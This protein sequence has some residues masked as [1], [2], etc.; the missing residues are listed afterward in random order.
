MPLFVIY[1]FCFANV[2]L[3][4]LQMFWGS[5]IVRALVKKLSGKEDKE[6]KGA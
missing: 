5:L 6:G 4:G 1:T 2:L 3:T